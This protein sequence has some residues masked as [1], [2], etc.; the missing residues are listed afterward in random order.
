MK[1]NRESFEADLA[2]VVSGDD[3]DAL[4]ELFPSRH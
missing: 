3:Y 4:M 1:A 2:N